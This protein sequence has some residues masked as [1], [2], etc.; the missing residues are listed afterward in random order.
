MHDV[1]KSLIIPKNI[2]DNFTKS[3]GIKPFIQ[4]FNGLVY[5]FFGSRNAP[6]TITRFFLVFILC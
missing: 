2:G 1:T 6:L 3:V 5:I 4:V